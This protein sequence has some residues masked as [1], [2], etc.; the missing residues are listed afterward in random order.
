[1]QIYWLISA[2]S[3]EYPLLIYV[4]S[5]IYMQKD[6]IFVLNVMSKCELNANFIFGNN[7]YT[8]KEK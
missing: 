6:I 2:L 5:I 1:M 3:D 7:T 8:H 4:N